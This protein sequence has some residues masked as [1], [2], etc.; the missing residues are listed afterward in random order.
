M[1]ETKNVDSVGA[2]DVSCEDYVYHLPEELIAAYPVEPRDSS[3]LLAKLTG[4]SRSKELSEKKR[5][6]FTLEDSILSHFASTKA[7]GQVLFDAH[8]RDLASL[9]PSNAHLVMNQSKVFPARMFAQ[10]DSDGGKT[11]VMFLDLEEKSPHN[12]TTDTSLALQ[13]NCNLQEWR[14]M[15]RKVGIVA[16]SKTYKTFSEGV[17]NVKLSLRVTKVHSDWLEEE[18]NGV[19]ATVQIIR[20]ETDDDREVTMAEAFE[21]FGTVPLPP[22]LGRELEDGDRAKYQTVYAKD[23]SSG[24]V[25]APT[26]GLHFTNNLLENLMKKGVKQSFV[27]LHV[28]A[29][30][31]RPITVDKISSHKMHREQ[32]SVDKESI[33]EILASL[34]EGKPIIPVGTTSVR[35]LESLYWFGSKLLNN[36]FSSN[37]CFDLGQWESYLLEQEFKR[38][39]SAAESL[40]AL[41]KVGDDIAIK[42]ST[43]MC[44]APGYKFRLCDGLITNF[45]QP[46]STLMLLVGALM[47]SPET[48]KETYSHAVKEK[49]RF[50]SFGDA[51][52]ILNCQE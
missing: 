28:G 38:L 14:A 31:F 40:A 45:H 37:V 36:E 12:P 27:N 17:T 9:L 35:V 18:G 20:E 24:S 51:S 23:T 47:N 42:G 46:H 16:G 19:E 21:L 3:R 25:A 44:I 26:A 22:Y 7:K 30:T 52:L 29:G 8:F 43:S 5:A 10:F 13:K 48:C 15:I 41:L 34:E 2:P 50:L 6:V 4:L 32:F 1:T 33:K 11:E 39:P 49:Y